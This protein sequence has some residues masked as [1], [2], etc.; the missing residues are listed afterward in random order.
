MNMIRY[1]I[2]GLGNQGSYYYS[3]AKDKKISNASFT[4]YD[5]EDDVKRL[6][7]TGKIL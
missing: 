3:L 2:I 1:G 6:N 5:K 4:G 7:F